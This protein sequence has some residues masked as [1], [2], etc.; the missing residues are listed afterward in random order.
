MA[1]ETFLRS[2]AKQIPLIK[3]LAKDLNF[4]SEDLNLMMDLH[5][6]KEITGQIDSDL[7]TEYEVNIFENGLKLFNAFFKNDLEDFE[8]S[9]SAGNTDDN[10]QSNFKVPPSPLSNVRLGRYNK[11]SKVDDSAGTSSVLRKPRKSRSSRN[12]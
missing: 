12:R 2:L 7:F 6:E 4:N 9:L 11:G 1:D 5:Q 8:T 3:Q 10:E